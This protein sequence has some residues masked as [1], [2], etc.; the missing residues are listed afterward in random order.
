[1]IWFVQQLREID[2]ESIPIENVQVRIII[3]RAKFSER[4][5]LERERSGLPPAPPKPFFEKN[6][7]PVM[8]V[9]ERGG[10]DDF[11]FIVFRTDLLR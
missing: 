10:F 3:C 1:M 5:R 2:E 11:G 6:D 8:E 9:V 4:Q 7:D